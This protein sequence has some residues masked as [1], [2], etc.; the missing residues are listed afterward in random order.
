MKSSNKN[1]AAYNSL[2]EIYRTKTYASSGTIASQVYDSQIASAI[3]DELYW[4]ES[5][6]SGT[7]IT[8]EVRASDT[9][10]AKDSTALAWTNLGTAGSPVD[11]NAAG[12]YFQ[13]RATLTTSG[14]RSVTPILHD[15]TV[16]YPSVT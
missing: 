10:F 14:D 11:L 8:F 2:F 3:W 12:K 9:S 1:K 15:V 5:L 16:Y 7:D 4:S 13:W 6:N